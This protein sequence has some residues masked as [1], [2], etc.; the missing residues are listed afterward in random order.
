[1]ESRRAFIAG[2]ESGAPVHLSFSAGQHDHLSRL[3]LW[4]QRFVEQEV[5]RLAYW[6]LAGAQ[7]KLDGGAHANP[8]RGIAGRAQALRGCRV[9]ERMRQDEFLDAH[10]A[11]TFQ[12]L[13]GD[14]GWG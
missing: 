1:M 6:L 12:R 11:R 9:P 7:T 4:R 10:S 14:H 8:W 13:E 5:P 3:R 2:C